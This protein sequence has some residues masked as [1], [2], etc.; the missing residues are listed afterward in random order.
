M[1]SL[2]FLTWFIDTLSQTFLPT[3]IKTTAA[4]VDSQSKMGTSEL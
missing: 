3:D 1:L 4:T 2:M